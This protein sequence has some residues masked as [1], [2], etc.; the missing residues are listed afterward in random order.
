[1]IKNIGLID[2]GYHAGSALYPPRAITLNLPNST[3]RMACC[4]VAG[5]RTVV[6][7]VILRTVPAQEHSPVV[8]RIGYDLS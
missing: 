2:A 8:G 4:G 7:G 5:E 1:M 6:L 3:R